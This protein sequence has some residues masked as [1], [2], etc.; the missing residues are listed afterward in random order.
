MSSLVTPSPGP[1]LQRE[2][3]RVAVAV[4]L[5]HPTLSGAPRGTAVAATPHGPR[6]AAQTWVH[7]AVSR[8]GCPPPPPAPAPPRTAPAVELA[9]PPSEG[10]SLEDQDEGGAQSE[11]DQEEGGLPELPE[12]ARLFYLVRLSLAPLPVKRDLGYGYTDGRM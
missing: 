11:E 2:A 6:S 10:R 9:A 3:P 5:G 8:L 12:G 4:R 1:G 7:P